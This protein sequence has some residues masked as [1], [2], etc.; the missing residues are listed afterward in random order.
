M[1]GGL[2]YV[3]LSANWGQR[4]GV[5]VTK[6]AIE[7]EMIIMSF[8][9]ALSA[10][11]LAALATW[12]QQAAQPHSPPKRATDALCRPS[13]LRDFCRVG[14]PDQTPPTLARHV[15]PN[16]KGLKNPLP[17]GVTIIELGVDLQGEVVS[18]CVIR[19][20]RADFDKAAQAAAWQWRFKLPVL[21][22]SERGFVLTVT[23]C[24]PDQRCHPKTSSTQKNG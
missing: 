14:C 18:A 23:V 7:P 17:S 9:C 10:M 6:R 21:T 16:T 5:K 19:G 8:P 11:A 15:A 13:L 3:K 4:S 24:T 22:G 2:R 1:R 20:L 12:G